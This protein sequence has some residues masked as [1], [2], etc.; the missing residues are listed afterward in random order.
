MKLIPF[1]LSISFS[2]TLKLDARWPDNKEITKGDALILKAV[3]D[4]GTM[5]WYWNSVPIDNSSLNGSTP[6]GLNITRKVAKIGN[7]IVKEEQTLRL[8]SMASKQ[9]GIYQVLAA[10]FDEKIKSEHTEVHSFG[11]LHK[12]YAIL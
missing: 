11:T 1:D 3:V 5:Q 10:G 12:E 8:E 6:N 9:S 4:Y 2:G 7:K